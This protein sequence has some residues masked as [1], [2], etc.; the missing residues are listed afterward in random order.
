MIFIVG[1]VICIAGLVGLVMLLRKVGRPKADAVIEEVSMEY[2]AKDKQQLKKHP[3]AKIKFNYRSMD[4]TAKIHL[5]RRKA[6]VGD[7]VV[8]AFKDESPEKP[9]MYAPKQE[10]IVVIVVMLIGLSLIGI[11]VFAMN[12]FDLW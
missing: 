11:S 8:V 1:V 12:Y 4:Y 5:L 2:M 3:H 10:T 9:V 7:M 6:Q